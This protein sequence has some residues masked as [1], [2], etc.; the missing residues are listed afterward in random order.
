MNQL[1]DNY[2]SYGRILASLGENTAMSD[3]EP[4]SIIGNNKQVDIFLEEM[5][6]N[7]FNISPVYQ[8]IM[9]R[10]CKVSIYDCN[11]NNR[12]MIFHIPEGISEEE[13]KTIEELQTVLA[14]EQWVKDNKKSSAFDKFISI[15]IFDSILHS[16]EREGL[17]ETSREEMT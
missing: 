7:G 5:M 17:I 6:K 11:E 14:S 16:Q 10:L 1:A 15:A 2:Q 4:Q 13:Q 9:R 3:I 12:D 8:G